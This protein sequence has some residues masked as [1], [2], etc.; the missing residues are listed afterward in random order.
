MSGGTPEVKICGLMRPED[1]RAADRAGAAFVGVILAEG[2]D[3]TLTPEEAERVLA[4]VETA[5]PVTVRVDDP[6][7]RVV[8]EA[9]RVGATVVQLHGDESPEVVARIGN[10]AGLEVWKAIRVRTTDDVL[11]AVRRYGEVADGLLLDG[12]HPDRVGG[13][14]ASFDWAQV[15]RLRDRIPRELRLIAAGG[16]TPDNVS[17]AVRALRPDVVDVSSGVEAERGIKDAG[18]IDAFIRAAGE[19]GE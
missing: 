5:R 6:P 11:R 8:D 7:E 19:Q 15:A 12:W 18:R 13:S 1:A 14:G 2:F 16:L 4:E 17:V 10:E 9:R 3:R